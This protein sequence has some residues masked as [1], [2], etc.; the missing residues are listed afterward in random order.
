MREPIVTKTELATLMAP[1]MWVMA[2][3]R[4]AAD[5]YVEG[6]ALLA[7]FALGGTAA[8]VYLGYLQLRDMQRSVQRRHEASIA[9]KAVLS[10]VHKS[11][12]PM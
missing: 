10:E 3:L 9:E 2:G 5:S 7:L 1:G 12:R 8:W 4:L 6:D 11:W